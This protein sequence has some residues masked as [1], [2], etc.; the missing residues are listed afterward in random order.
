MNEFPWQ[1]ALVQRG[2]PNQVFCG[3][4]IINKRCMDFTLKVFVFFH[5]LR[6]QICHDCC[7][8]HNRVGFI[9]LNIMHWDPKTF[10]TLILPAKI[11]SVQVPQA[12]G[13]CLECWTGDNQ[14]MM[15]LFKLL[16][17]CIL[18]WQVKA[19]NL[20]LFSL[21]LSLGRWSTQTTIATPWNMTSP[22]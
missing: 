12:F 20:Q 9:N 19:M 8:L 14:I 18:L 3:A 10:K 13:L 22:C 15:L 11:I 4:T 17:E 5:F 6:F 7:A 2:H 21:F 16:S 1:A